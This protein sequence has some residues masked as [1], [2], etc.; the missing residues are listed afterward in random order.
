MPAN[1]NREIRLFVLKIQQVLAVAGA[2]LACAGLPENVRSS[3]DMKKL[4]KK[5]EERNNFLHNILSI[6]TTVKIK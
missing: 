4:V 6:L 2:M 5:G 3:A 1:L